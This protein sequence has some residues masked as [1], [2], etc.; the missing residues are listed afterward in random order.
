[1]C[2]DLVARK[3]VKLPKGWMLMHQCKVAESALDKISCQS[4]SLKRNRCILAWLLKIMGD[5]F[6]KS[7]Q[8]H[9]DMEHC[10]SH[11]DSAA[12][13]LA[14]VLLVKI[15]NQA[16]AYALQSHSLAMHFI[17]AYSDFG[18]NLTPVEGVFQQSAA[19]QQLQIVQGQQQRLPATI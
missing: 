9:F 19:T 17:F 1:M 3:I 18:T 12:C 11:L 6:R 4:Q 5:L 15:C 10:C 14:K 7:C 8:D 16:Q 2:R 13:A